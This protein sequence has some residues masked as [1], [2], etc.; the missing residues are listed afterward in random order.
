MSFL[1]I[2]FEEV[3]L[4]PPTLSDTKVGTQKSKMEDTLD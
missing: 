2:P 1:E 4:K 3:C